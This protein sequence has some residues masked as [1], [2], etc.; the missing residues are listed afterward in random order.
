MVNIPELKNKILRYIES[1]G[2]SLPIRIA[3]IAES[4]SLFAGAVL[5]ELISSKQ[6]K[7]SNAKIGGSPVYYLPGQEQKLSLLFQYLP[8][9]EKE[10]YTLL[11]QKR[12]AKDKDL[13]PSIRVALRFLK[14]FA[15]PFTYDGEEVAWRWH[16]VA[17]AEARQLI[18]PNKKIET[19]KKVE[20]QQRIEP[21]TQ[22]KPAPTVARKK[23]K[24]TKKD[25]LSEA[26][27]G[28]LARNNMQIVERDII[29]KNVE[30][31]LTV[32]VPSAL[33]TVK[34]FVVVRN[35][36]RITENDLMVA[37]HKGQSKRLAAVII[38]TGELTKKA[39]EYMEKNLK[40]SLVFKKLR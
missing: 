10:A 27:Q 21:Q 12:T 34:M 25:E 38:G 16:L 1:N 23:T 6:I 17:E 8:Q 2:P 20:V 28:Y 7:I 4:D 14:D 24:S 3:K 18:S 32:A 31:N 40:G 5:S 33:G 39:E 11:E 36:R 13:E 15:V 9:R 29:K 19:I 37:S 26:I 30:I 35:K 22:N